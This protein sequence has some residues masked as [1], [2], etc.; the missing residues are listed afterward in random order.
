MSGNILVS[1][2]SGRRTLLRLVLSLAATAVVAYL[3]WPVALP[4]LERVHMEPL[5]GIEN[6]TKIARSAVV[7]V[8]V[9]VVFSLLSY[10]FERLLPDNGETGT[11]PWRVEDETLTLGE[12]SIPL[13][14]IRRV[15]CW[16]G[17]NILGQSTGNVVV[18]IETT[19]KNQ[20]LRSLDGE[21]ARES[22]AALEELVRA[23]GYGAAWDAAIGS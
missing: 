21:R 23:L 4:F 18:N 16:P 22:E 14:S 20:V 13:E 8:G 5:W 17:R 19:G 1:A 15:H 11:L 12:V 2:G 3:L 9:Y 6:M 7:A 10:C